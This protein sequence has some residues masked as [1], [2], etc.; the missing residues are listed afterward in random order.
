[1]SQTFEERLAYFREYA[2]G[3]GSFIEF[4]DQYERFPELD[5][6][7]HDLHTRGAGCMCRDCLHAYFLDIDPEA[8]EMVIGRIERLS[9][10]GKARFMEQVS[11]W[12]EYAF[13]PDPE[14][15]T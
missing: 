12:R 14:G 1:M 6:T 13:G 8:M 2:L 5:R 11:A 4:C 9:P 3:L 10:A 15:S 7:I